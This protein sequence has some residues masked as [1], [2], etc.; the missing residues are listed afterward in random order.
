MEWT[1]EKQMTE[2]NSV[3]DD[4][5][6]EIQTENKT[7]ITENNE[8]SNVN[9]RATT[10]N[11]EKALLEE[12]KL[13]KSKLI[14][15]G[16]FN[17]LEIIEG[18]EREYVTLKKAQE[19]EKNQEPGKVKIDYEQDIIYWEVWEKEYI[20]A[21]YTDKPALLSRIDSPFKVVSHNVI[22]K[23]CDRKDYPQKFGAKSRIDLKRL[24]Q[25]TQD[26]MVLSGN[27]D[28]M[29]MIMNDLLAKG[30]CS[31]KLNET[32]HF[33]N[34]MRRLEGERNMNNLTEKVSWNKNKAKKENEIE[35]SLNTQKLMW[36]SNLMEMINFK[37]KISYSTLNN[38]K[39]RRTK[40]EWHE[41]R[42][43]TTES[44][45]D[46]T[47]VT[48]VEIMNDDITTLEV[49][50]SNTFHAITHEGLTYIGTNS[51]IKY[52]FTMIE[53]ET[54]SFMIKDINLASK[55][56]KKIK[57]NDF[58]D[59]VIGLKDYENPR[60]TDIAAS[61]ETLCLMMAD[62]KA[63]SSNLPLID[64]IFE[65][66]NL[67]IGFTEKLVTLCMESDLDTCIRM[68][69]INKMN[70]FAEVNVKSGLEKY[71]RRTNRNH[72]VDKNSVEGLRWLFRMRIITNYIKKYG[73]VPPLQG[74]PMNL[75]QELNLMASG[76]SY[77]SDIIS[78][79]VNYKNVKM[80]QMLQPGQE[81]NIASRVIDKACT[82]DKYD[83]SGNSV[84]ELIYYITNSNLPDLMEN[85]EISKIKKE[86]D[87]EIMVSDRKNKDLERMEEFK[88]VRLVE[89]EKELKTDA[90]FYGV[91]SFK[92]KIYISIVMEMIKRAMKLLPGQ[93]M[94]MSEDERRH[95]MHEMSKILDEE[96]SYSIF[97]DYSGHNTSQ[98]P[99]NTSFIME[100][101]ADMYGFKE[102]T[103]EREKMISIVYLFSDISIIYEELFSDIIVKSEYQKGAIEGWF[104]PLW[105]IQ[106]QLMMEDMMSALN[107]KKFIGTT[108]SDDSCGVFIKKDLT[109]RSLDEIIT[110]VQNYSLK[111]GLLVKLS[112]T[113]ITNGRCSMLKN[114]YFKDLPIDM[115]E[116]RIF[117]ISGNTE[118]LW[119]DDIERMMTI[120]SGYTSSILRS[121]ETRTQTIIRNYRA[122]TV[123]D[124]ELIRWCSQLNVSMDTSYISNITALSK[125]AELCLGKVKSELE[126]NKEEQSILDNKGISLEND[127]IGSF[128][129]FNKRNTKVLS[130]ALM[131]MYLPYT[132]YGYSSTSMIDG[133]IS[134]FSISNVK[135]IIYVN[136]IIDEELKIKLGNLVH[137][138][139]KAKNYLLEPFPMDGGR[140]DTKTLLKDELKKVLKDKVENKQLKE[141][142]N[143]ASREDEDLFKLE[144]LST[145][146]FCMSHRIT[147]KFFECSIFK[148]LDDI[149]SKIDNSTTL[150]FFVGKRRMNKLWNK[151]WNVNHNLNLKFN[152]RD[153]EVSFDNLIRWRRETRK[154][155]EIQQHDKIAEQE[156]EL[157]FLEIE[158]LPIIGA[159]RESSSSG[160]LSVV[161]KSGMVRTG[162]KKNRFRR[163]GPMRTAINTTK[164][165]RDLE[166]EGMFTN[167]LIFLAYE[168]VR[169]V[170][171]IIMDM[172]KFS[173]VSK[174]TI[175]SLIKM[176]DV[177]LAS[178]SD[179][180]F[181]DI[182]AGVVCPSGGRYFHR[183]LT[184]GFNPRTG[185]LTSN[186]KSN[187]YEVTGVS[188]FQ[189]ITGGVDN[190]V[191]L[192]L[193]ITTLKITAG[194]LDFPW[195]QNSMLTL[196]D[197][198]MKHAR[199]VSFSL[200]DIKPSDL[201]KMT[202]RLKEIPSELKV[203]KL[204]EKERLYK[205]YSYHI[206]TDEDIKGKFLDHKIVMPIEKIDE[207]SS[208]MT[209]HKYMADQEIVSPDSIPQETL[210]RIA[211]ELKN[212]VSRDAYLDK[213]YH[214]YKG[215]NIIGRESY[216]KTI[217]RNMINSELFS[218][219]GT[220]KWIQEMENHGF[221]MA[222]RRILMKLFIISTCLVF[223]MEEEGYG[224]MRMRIAKDKTKSNGMSNLTRMKKGEA[225]FHIKDKRVSELIMMSFP[226]TGY[227]FKELYNGIDELYERYN[228][229]LFETEKLVQYYDVEIKDYIKEEFIYE[230]GS[231]SFEEM[232]IGE[233]DLENEKMM[234]AA[235]KGY[236][237]VCTL[238][239]KPQH[240]SSP[241][242][243]DVYPTALSI[244]EHL[245]N[246][247]IIRE[248]TR[249]L[250]LFAGR[251]DFHCALTKLGVCHDSI[252]RNDGYNLI[253]RIP[254]MREIKASIDATASEFYGEYLDAD[255]L[256]ADI[257]HMTCSVEN[258]T[259]LIDDFVDNGKDVIL[260]VNSVI[261]HGSKAL[262]HFARDYNTTL[263]IPSIESPGYVYM[264][265]SQS[266]TSRPE[267]LETVKAF[268]E[269]IIAEKMTNEIF[270][271]RKESMFNSRCIET[272]DHTME[273]I[274]DEKI[275]EIMLEDV[276]GNEFIETSCEDKI[277]RGKK[278][279]DML[280]MEFESGYELKRNGKSEWRFLDEDI[281]DKIEF[282][283]PIFEFVP[284]VKKNKKEVI[285]EVIEFRNKDRKKLDEKLTIK[286]G[287]DF[288]IGSGQF[289]IGSDNLTREEGLKLA[290]HI[291]NSR[292]LSHDN[293][294]IW[295]MIRIGIEKFNEEMID[296]SELVETIELG[297][298]FREKYHSFDRL[299]KITKL[300]KNAYM[301]GKISESLMMLAG[302]KRGSIRT[303]MEN[304]TRSHRYDCLNFKLIIN[305]MML[306]KQKMNIE[307]SR[308]KKE[309]AQL[310]THL[311]EMRTKKKNRS[312]E[313]CLFD[314]RETSVS[315]EEIE[316]RIE[317][318][319]KLLES[320]ETMED[321]LKENLN[322]ELF[323]AIRDSIDTE[324][325]PKEE[326]EIELKEDLFSDMMKVFSGVT[327]EEIER[328]RNKTVEEMRREVEED[329]WEEY[330]D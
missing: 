305:R 164:F 75:E 289:I 229:R 191:N 192:A 293:F 294:M 111:M 32:F 18:K 302:I 315:E 132:M 73:M 97:L 313:T 286:V 317:A 59:I 185:D 37:I 16:A 102:G 159:I 82:K 173:S 197:D 295:K 165:D 202:H 23:L 44:F 208:F 244:I 95:I 323:T 171:W 278:A 10:G 20:S 170:K 283:N 78:N 60:R 178:F 217:M 66:I 79:K 125:F 53:N 261:N 277:Q 232:S 68:S 84:K 222:H 312:F 248:D 5:I 137:L 157:K 161:K 131:L 115:S 96:D 254:G 240:L 311:K 175:N 124:K 107:F 215:L 252:S 103:K 187:T 300:A 29:I 288:R 93:M 47:S 99:E 52:L 90:R 49:F 316:K 162:I 201:I 129:H 126:N 181:D 140:F 290:D 174:G 249:V 190:N 260:R 109:E 46:G 24:R 27:Q 3:T 71:V 268:K 282:I 34:E 38:H 152:N 43:I 264:L 69:G 242:M 327:E 76:G 136:S 169:Y 146:Q 8:D 119:G 54:T 58:H 314:K 153:E 150:S 105:G 310:V 7:D 263:L 247:K 220:T 209:L 255:V 17:T 297:V 62:S 106:S 237:M 224:R 167:K 128:F 130:A 250:D 262:A 309:F 92:L 270:N 234:K 31:T 139:K 265:I 149:Y 120:D 239:C 324:P 271:L 74:A 207:M 269:S 40:S 226:T 299:I 276:E 141:V 86:F 318:E 257:S 308:D 301:T 112:Q 221:S 57:E 108:Y 227:T 321:Y 100:E 9:V 113:Q 199:D 123:V 273:L 184:G 320:Y 306:L 233:K 22:R 231:I 143:L 83:F 127:L 287:N 238:H 285:L 256:I 89:K 330:E 216:T 319:I 28:D 251:G 204:K 35:L 19:R 65:S 179:C 15:N 156:V 2:S 194:Q 177:T 88:I 322:N 166:I 195:V 230:V 94:T 158:E 147:A 33:G 163:A 144:L 275:L 210:E 85:M 328:N 72:K 212:N 80:G 298:H 172:E 98:R 325:T 87:R 134:G 228:N 148:Y 55:N 133:M 67:D 176:T 213:F 168:L 4:F 205:S 235:I 223:K 42:R 21:T 200:E 196:S 25:F 281:V 118:V 36:L 41:N 91:A 219:L 272:R 182:S 45:N 246:S 266:G 211:P 236:E 296:I 11:D 259:K 180:T 121:D 303:L 63:K 110:F 12:Y 189:D 193:L 104:G 253:N 39:P 186:L 203:E 1:K 138:S 183:A 64:C 160:V 48:K 61:Y 145:F 188:R 274:S 155:I 151:A 154:I 30:H 329:E 101:I 56:E 267:S 241:T 245:K 198:V 291:I 114:H 292:W 142:L 135:R 122:L 14:S 304:K 116:K 218:G 243:S 6:V 13:V 51:M 206:S 307:L 326:L 70:T 225:H 81:V 26:K 50:M 279:K 284:D 258:L 77:N 280:V 117:S 214:F